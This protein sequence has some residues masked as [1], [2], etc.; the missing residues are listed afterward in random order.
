ML[1]VNL[2]WTMWTDPEHIRHWEPS[3]EWEFIMHVPDGTDYRNKHIYKE[4]VKPER[5]VMEHVTSPKF[6][7]MTTF[8]AQENKTLLTI[9]SIFESAEQLQEVIKVFKADEG[10]KQNADRL[11]EY[12]SKS[13]AA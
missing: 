9:H 12:L 6:V 10:M 5:L 2:A 3:G 4:V 11:E 13:I 8:E 1:R 7:M